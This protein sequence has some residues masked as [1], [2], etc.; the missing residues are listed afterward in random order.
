MDLLTVQ[1]LSDLMELLRELYPEK[2]IA[3]IIESLQKT[4][5]EDYS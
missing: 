5:L 2:T 4:P 3:N 1:T